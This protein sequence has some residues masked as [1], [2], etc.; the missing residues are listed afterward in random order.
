M[1]RDDIIA[2][3]GH[4]V[5]ARHNFFERNTAQPK[6]VG[7]YREAETWVV[8]RSDERGADVGRRFFES[9]AEALDLFARLL[10]GFI[11]R[12]LDLAW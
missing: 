5:L 4:E 8:Y 3:F 6:E 2:E 7:I 1:K 9:E 11:L 10:R 12:R